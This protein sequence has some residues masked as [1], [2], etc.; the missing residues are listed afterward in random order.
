M[1]DIDYTL[2]IWR[3]VAIPEHQDSYEVSD[4]GRV[5]CVKPNRLKILCL[6]K[7]SRGYCMA[8]LSWPESAQK[9]ISVHRLVA[10]T[11]IG[12]P[13]TKDHVIAHND[14]I[15]D[16]NYVHNLRWATY[17]ENEADK[18]LH[19]TICRGKKNHSTKL[20]KTDIESI[21]RLWE[22]G[23]QQ[24]K[25]AEQYGVSPT[26]ICDILH[27]RTWNYLSNPILTADNRG[28]NGSN[29]KLKTADVL[30]IHELRSLGHSHRAIASIFG[31]CR[32]NVSKILQ[33]KSWSHLMP[34]NTSDT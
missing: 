9:M 33:G 26:C 32:E 25:I 21:F 30:Q 15:R 22:T 10:L 29:A 6:S 27:G 28:E 19:G 1:S 5:R 12:P 18:L 7:S 8:H 23:L 14:G 31:V 11:F 17:K 2:E 3:P 4:H 24:C 20:S 13:P 16:N 34:T